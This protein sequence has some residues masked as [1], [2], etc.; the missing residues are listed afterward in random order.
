MRVPHY[1]LEK[2][3]RA[4]ADTP[5]FTGDCVSVCAD[6]TSSVISRKVLL[7]SHLCV[8]EYRKFGHLPHFVARSNRENRHKNSPPTDYV[9]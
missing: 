4:F 1:I 2:L 8:N 9:R 5:N 3:V 6:R 7:V